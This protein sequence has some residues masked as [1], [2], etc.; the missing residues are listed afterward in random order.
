MRPLT[1][2]ILFAISVALGVTIWW[3]DRESAATVAGSS[4][5]ASDEGKVLARVEPEQL[6]KLVIKRPAGEVT[7]EK[8]DGYWYFA[9]PIV[10]RADPEGMAA[11]IDI[12]THL[13]VL[14]QIPIDEVGSRDELSPDAL[15][16]TAEQVTRVE[17]TE[18]P[19]DPAG[20]PRTQAVLLGQATPLTGSIYARLPESEDRPDVYVVNGSPGKYLDDPVA[21]LR[22]RHLF[23]APADQIVQ[24]TVRTPKG[25]IEMKRRIVPPVADWTLTKPL[26]TAA[27][28][29]AIES[30]LA[31][32]AGLRVETVTASGDKP[33]P[34]P[35]PIPDGSLAIDLWRYGVESPLT[36]FLRPSPDGAGLI[37]ATVSDREAVFTLKSDLLATLPSTPD[38]FR[39]PHL[40]R[41]S[42]ASVF[43][44]A[45]ESRGNP[46]VVLKTARTP[47]GV[48]WFSL[49]N[50]V[51]ERANESQIATLLK[52]LN[53]EKVIAFVSD[54][55]DRLAE[56]NLSPPAVQI[57]ISHYERLPETAPDGAAA[58]SGGELGAVKKVLQLGYT[59]GDGTGDTQHRLFANFAGEPFI[60]EISPGF[61]E[62]V[63]THPLKWKDL[64]LLTFNPISLRRIERRSGGAD[65]RT[66]ALV[67]D[68][69]RDHWTATE[70][71]TDL[72]DR[73]NR[74]AA[75]KLR[76]T[77]GSLAAMR[78]LTPSPQA[79]QAIEMP[80][81]EFV[82]VLE[83]VDRA[84]GKPRETTHQLRFA[85]T[86]ARTPQGDFLSYYG[87]LDGSP[88]LFEVDA[89]TYR[90]LIAPVIGTRIA[91]EP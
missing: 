32:L 88:D 33:A 45:I 65:A 28:R 19:A 80:D 40:A 21:T 83:T 90:H 79:F 8:R 69:R 48:R 34:P 86:G 84:T 29:A 44:I 71:E 61:R 18:S 67:Y 56:F 31:S 85:R 5:G 27:D 17:L 78:W 72:S 4:S 14:D 57:A 73:V 1:T 24:I 54:S 3:T 25:D 39:D 30:L 76:E 20:E 53:E 82:I 7:L 50:G 68:Y 87:Q 11:L 37:Q 55:P 63:P 12:L 70:A 41:L 13:T 66:L 42:P 26:Q 2:V 46:P 43:G 38:G 62:Q 75:R 89:E 22:D 59:E 6:S 15:G 81:A 74:D 52:A 47:D 10:D 58:G 77:L 49:R 36:L 64:R 9:A 23:L 35:R 91:P 16:L 51:E 60:Q